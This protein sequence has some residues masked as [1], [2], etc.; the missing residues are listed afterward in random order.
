MM[1]SDPSFALSRARRKYKNGGV[2]EDWCSN[3]PWT[4]VLTGNG[5][6]TDRGWTYWDDNGT[7]PDSSFWVFHA[8][9]GAGLMPDCLGDIKYVEVSTVEF[10][11]FSS[12]LRAT[13]LILLMLTVRHSAS[14]SPLRTSPASCVTTASLWTTSPPPVM[15]RGASAASST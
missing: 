9:D 8:C 1:H 4:Q 7:Y 14:T 10:R 13:R 5:F 15:T 11:M 12:L 6:K 3:D 2:D